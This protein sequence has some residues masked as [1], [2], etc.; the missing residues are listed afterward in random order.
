MP[1]TFFFVFLGSHPSCTLLFVGSTQRQRCDSRKNIR[2]SQSTAHTHR[3]VKPAPFPL[4][5]NSVTRFYSSHHSDGAD[6][7]ETSSS[8]P[9]IQRTTSTSSQG[10]KFCFDWCMYS[11]TWENWCVAD[12]F[13]LLPALVTLFHGEKCEKVLEVE[14]E[15][16]KAWEQLFAEYGRFAARWRQLISNTSW[17]WRIV[18]L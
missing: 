2:L 12:D 9:N 15:Q 3:V 7:V 4:T 11:F 1:A 8:S 14:E 6:V 13:E 17:L 5:I 16:E 10:F 18:L